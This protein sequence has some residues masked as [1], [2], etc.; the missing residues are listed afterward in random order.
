MTKAGRFHSVQL[1]EA[2]R[3]L[4]RVA[5]G[6][7]GQ[8]KGWQLEGCARGREGSGGLCLG[9]DGV[10]Q[11]LPCCQPL[12]QAGGNKYTENRADLK[13]RQVKINIAFAK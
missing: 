1:P 10:F 11:S 3:G 8:G 7:L 9:G 6:G 2:G 4:G 13:Q 5:D 12:Q